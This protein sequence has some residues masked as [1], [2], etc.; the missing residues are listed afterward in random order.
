MKFKV[1]NIVQDQNGHRVVSFT[2]EN[3][4]TATLNTSFSPESAFHLVHGQ[5]VE[6]AVDHPKVKK[7]KKVKAKKGRK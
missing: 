7:T 1:T 2:A 6:F 5:E 3:G 4:D